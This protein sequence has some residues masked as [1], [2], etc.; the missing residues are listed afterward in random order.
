MWRSEATKALGRD[1]LRDFLLRDTPTFNARSQQDSSPSA[2][3]SDATV[4]NASD[5]TSL[6]SA[7]FDQVGGNGDGDD[8]R[9]FTLNINPFLLAVLYDN[10]IYYDQSVYEQE[11]YAWLRSVG[12]SITSGGK[13][14]SFDRDGDGKAEDALESEAFDDIITWEVRWRF[15]GSRDRRENADA[16]FAFAEAPKHLDEIQKATDRIEDQV[17][18]DHAYDPKKVHC[19]HDTWIQANKPKIDAAVAAFVEASEAYIAALERVDRKLLVTAVATG[20]ERKRDFGSDKHGLGLRASWMGIDANAEWMHMGGL[21]QGA[22]D[23]DQFKL[24][25]EYSH[26]LLQGWEL[27]GWRLKRPEKGKKGKGWL[28]N[29][30]DASISTALEI[31]DDT[32]DVDHDT[33]L[34]IQGKLEIPITEGVRFPISITWANHEDLLDKDDKIVGHFGINVDTSALSGLAKKFF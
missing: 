26:Q 16:I 21:T 6:L 17:L 32:P 11:R 8:N 28:K 33:N 22:E 12:G 13:G 1:D 3:G 5:F 23:M 2:N 4:V 15:I 18:R 34:K 29:G 20:V 14:E 27:E 25:V 30:I 31:Y 7:A 9:G 24:G 10:Q 19:V